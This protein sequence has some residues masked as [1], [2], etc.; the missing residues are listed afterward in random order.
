MAELYDP[1]GFW[2]PWK[3]Q[4][5]LMSQTLTGIDRDEHIH[6]EDQDVWKQQL[7][8]QVDF[9]KLSVPRICIPADQDLL[10]RILLICVTDAAVNAGGAAVYPGRK[11]KDSTWSCT[12]VASKSKL[13]KAKV[14]QNEISAIMLGTELIYLVAKSIG[15]RV[16][17]VIF[18]TDSK[19]ALS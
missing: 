11:L 2:E 17:D 15:S 19:I 1:C 8:R 6:H 7:S 16:E 3:L 5:K 14:P 4:L 18:A 13:M 10:S 9:Q 12:L